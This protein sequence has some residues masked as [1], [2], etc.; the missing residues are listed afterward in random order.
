MSAYDSNA[1][2]LP[3]F[4]RQMAKRCRTRS[5][6]CFDLAAARDLRLLGDDLDKKADTLEPPGANEGRRS[7]RNGPHFPGSSGS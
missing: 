4:L 3:T 6:N 1:T 2:D 7:Q 5:Q